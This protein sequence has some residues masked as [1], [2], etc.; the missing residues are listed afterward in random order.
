MQ[1]DGRAVD[2]IE[3]IY[4]F[5]VGAVV[6]D[7]RLSRQRKVLRKRREA[8]VNKFGAVVGDDDH[9]DDGRVRLSQHDAVRAFHEAPKALALFFAHPRFDVDRWSR[10]G[11][12]LH[13]GGFGR[14]RRRFEDAPAPEDLAARGAPRQPFDGA[15][16]AARTGNRAAQGKGQ[17]PKR[18]CLDRRKPLLRLGKALL[19]LF[20]QG[21][22]GLQLPAKLHDLGG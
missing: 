6:E 17:F 1:R 18:A 8:P 7:D 10:F 19:T 5:L 13:G 4:G 20:R 11:C 16:E 2:P 9:R 3:E 21:M 22:P 15:A 14:R 12:G